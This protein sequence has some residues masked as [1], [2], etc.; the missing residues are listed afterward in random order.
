MDFKYL[1]DQKHSVELESNKKPSKRIPVMRIN[2]K[3]LK[4]KL[5]IKTKKPPKIVLFKIEIFQIEKIFDQLICNFSFF[6]C[7][8]IFLFP[9]IFV[10]RTFMYMGKLSLVFGP[11]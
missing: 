8:T 9:G 2:P 1:K 3:N 7:T 4:S 10:N 5:F 11:K 6:I